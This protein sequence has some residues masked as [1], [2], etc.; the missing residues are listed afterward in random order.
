MSATTSSA[1]PWNGGRSP[2][3]TLALL[4]RTSI[5]TRIVSAIDFGSRPARWAQPWIS[6]TLR[7]YSSGWR[8]AGGRMAIGCQPSPMVPALR[9]RR[10]AERLELL[11]QPADAG[12]EDHAA[13]REDVRRRQHLGGEQG[14]TVGDDED[15][16]A[17]PDPGRRVSEVTEHRQ[18]LEVVLGEPAGKLPARRVGI[19]R[20]RRG[21]RH[22][23]VVGDEQRAVPERVRLLG[24]LEDDVEPG[25]RPTTW[26]RKPELHDTPP[27]K[28]FR[29]ATADMVSLSGMHFFDVVVIGAGHA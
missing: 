22:H 20:F 6:V 29:N 18:R 26:K 15:A 21:D 16:D 23:D 27:R 7:A 2:A 3:A 5:G 4:V 8:R 1:V 11:A 25:Q 28:G 13:L 12:A 24:E 19:H 9:E 10:G 17:E 14:I